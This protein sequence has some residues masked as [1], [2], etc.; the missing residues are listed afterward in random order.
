MMCT[1]TYTLLLSFAQRIYKKIHFHEFA[2]LDTKRAVLVET[3]QF[4]V[5]LLW[6]SVDLEDMSWRVSK[7][8][9]EGYVSYMSYIK[10]EGEY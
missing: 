7:Q 4:S 9:K 2:Q 6:S 3:P 10:E 1:K 8:S 5:L